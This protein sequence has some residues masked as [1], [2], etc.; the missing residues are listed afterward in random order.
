MPAQTLLP[1][2]SFIGLSGM[3][4]PMFQ[5]ARS[6]RTDDALRLPLSFPHK[7]FEGR[8]RGVVSRELRFKLGHASP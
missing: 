6:W 4:G 5:K 2:G 3:V 8:E 1:H 7:A